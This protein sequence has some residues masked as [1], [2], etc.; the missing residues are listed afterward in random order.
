MRE[1]TFALVS[2]GFVGGP[3]QAMREFLV[4]RGAGRVIS[5]FH[6]LVTQ[7]EPVHEVRIWE[8]GELVRRRDYKLPSRPPLTYPLDLLVP[9]LLPPVDCWIGFN[10]LATW[11]GALARRLGRADKLV[12]WCVD[13]VRDRFGKGAL[14][15]VYQSLDGYCCRRSDLRVELS[16]AAAEARTA[17]HLGQLLAPVEI[18]GMGAWIDRLAVVPG[19]GYGSRRVVYLGNLIPT[20][21]GPLLIQSLAL[22]ANENFNF[23]VDII[24]R[25]P[26]EAQLR[27]RVRDLGLTD[28]VKFHGFVE[29]ELEVERLLATASVGVAPYDPTGETFSRWADPAKLKAYLAAGLP[30]ILT[31]VP[32][33]AHELQD[34]GAAEIVSFTPE[35][36]SGAIRRVID[37]PEEWTRRH[38]AALRLRLKYDW[39]V[40]LPDVLRSLGFSS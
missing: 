13:F 28:R 38:R 36:L 7:G 31:D 27:S 24:G 33:N 22:L 19:D 39:A 25:G 2:N 17:R 10:A 40:M 5:V 6:P 32:P 21:G 20:Q 29:D 30:V 16:Q 4:T 37:S 3:A 11:R 14:T 34:A 8:R 35:A 9:L 15:S 12:Y 26:L 1:A 18:V 23:K